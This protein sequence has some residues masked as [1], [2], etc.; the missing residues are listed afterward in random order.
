[1]KAEH[2]HELKTN[3]LAKSLITF[4]DYVKVYGGRVAL[5]AAIVILVIVLI[6]QRVSNSRREAL[7]L[8]DDLAFARSLIDRLSRAQIDR[9]GRPT[10]K[11]ADVEQ[12]RSLLLKVR[13]NSSDK[14]LQA[15]A[16]VEMG[17]YNWA[18]ANYPEAPG[19]ATQPSAKL[20]KDRGAALSDAKAAYQQVL[21]GYGDQMM[22]VVAARFG[23][24][25]IAENERAWDDAKKHYEAV[26]GIEAAPEMYK[27]LA[28]VKLQ[29]IE[30]IRQ[31]MLV[32]EVPDRPEFPPLL[33]T[34]TTTQGTTTQTSTMPATGAA[35]ATSVATRGAST[36]PAK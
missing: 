23:L 20:D 19:A 5:G 32:G 4:Q 1:M 3:D 10:V 9:L 7:E 31:P 12:A 21:D 36:R 33:P 6:M 15:E 35:A 28:N 34:T 2:R 25:A 8:R 26:K 24:A 18:L 11:P 14:T 17:N 13:E 16:L 27:T 30:E 22:S 29:R